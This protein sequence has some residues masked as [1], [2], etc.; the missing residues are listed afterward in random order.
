MIFQTQKAIAESAA[1]ATL[2]FEEIHAFHT[3]MCEVQLNGTELDPC[4]RLPFSLA[5][6][7]ADEE[8]L[9]SHPEVRS[10]L[11][12]FTAAVLADKP[13]DVRAYACDHFARYYAATAATAS[14]MAD[15]PSGARR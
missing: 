3:R 13:A 1:G 5:P 14:L 11:Q 7:R 15:L 12:D 8:W 9:A 4:T 6:A 2:N 10:I